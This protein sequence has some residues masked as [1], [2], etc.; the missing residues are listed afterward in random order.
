MAPH[1]VNL[2]DGQAVVT[3]VADNVAA[4]P[5]LLVAV[6]VEDVEAVA[7]NS[8]STKTSPDPSKVTPVGRAVEEYVIDP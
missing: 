7:T 6:I 5:H 2:K 3:I 1:G 4:F 8:G